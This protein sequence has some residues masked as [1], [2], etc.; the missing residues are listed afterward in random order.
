MCPDPEI[1]RTLFGYSASRHL[2]PVSEPKNTGI[3][4]R[5]T[6]DRRFRLSVTVLMLLSDRS[7]TAGTGYREQRG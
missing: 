5:E 3:A 6:M 7:A 1:K 4:H 2:P